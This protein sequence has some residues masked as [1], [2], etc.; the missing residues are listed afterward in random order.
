MKSSSLWLVLIPLAWMAGCASAPS[1]SSA[2]VAAAP[3]PTVAAPECNAAGA[4][5]AVGQVATAQLESAAAHRAS[6]STVR[7]LR[8][9][10]V[11]T[12]ELNSRRLNL[13]VNAQGRV[14]AVHCG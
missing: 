6:A 3:P 14:T 13:D 7:S 1:A 10:Q 2:P 8:P 11:V 5:F 9:G 4:Q 12:M